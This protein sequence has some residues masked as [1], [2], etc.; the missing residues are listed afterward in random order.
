MEMR[1]SCDELFG[2]AVAVTPCDTI[3]AAIALANDSI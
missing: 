1:I 3:A 2:L